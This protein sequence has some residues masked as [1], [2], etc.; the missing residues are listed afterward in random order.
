MLIKA[1]QRFTMR[2]RNYNMENLH[3]SE[4]TNGSAPASSV[5]KVS[6]ISPTIG[7]H[8]HTAPASKKVRPR[9]AFLEIL[10]PARKWYS[11]QW[12]PTRMIEQLYRLKAKGAVLP[13]MPD[14][15]PSVVRFKKMNATKRALFLMMYIASLA[16]TLEMLKTGRQLPGDQTRSVKHQIRS[17]QRRLRRACHRA[18]EVGL[19][20]NGRWKIGSLMTLGNKGVQGKSNK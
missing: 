10:S 1:W 17:A 11:C 14:R 5:V 8:G 9:L 16:I 7:V 15:L 13:K 18:E 12:V 6:S 19:W 4:Y 3:S 2:K 20:H